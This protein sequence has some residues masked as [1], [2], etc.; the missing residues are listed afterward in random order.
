[1]LLFCKFVVKEPLTLATLP[2]KSKT[3][4]RPK[5]F[6]E[7][8]VDFS[9]FL[10]MPEG[11]EKLFLLIYIIIIPY[12][13]GLIFLFIFVAKGRFNDFISLDL[14]MFMAVW[15]I[16]YEVVGSIALVVIFYK[17]LRFKHVEAEQSSRRQRRIGSGSNL[18][19]VHDLS[20]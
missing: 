8:E 10:P 5:T 14:A 15:A 18:Y 4:K 19:E 7:K 16:G 2:K 11:M 17:M 13:T 20:K 12:V 6:G 9:T 3:R 1:M